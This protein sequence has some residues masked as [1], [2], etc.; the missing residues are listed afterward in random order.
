MQF[1]KKKVFLAV[2]GLF[3]FYLLCRVTPMTIHLPYCHPAWHQLQHVGLL[4]NTACPEGL[5]LLSFH[6]FAISLQFHRPSSEFVKMAVS[7]MSKL[8]YYYS[9]GHFSF[10]IPGFTAFQCFTMRDHMEICFIAATHRM[11][12]LFAFWVKF[13]RKVQTAV[14]WV[15]FSIL[16]M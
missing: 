16:W 13:K 9:L 10:Y 6:Y 8:L 7:F 5:N 4:V 12:M 1:K 2:T 15:F 14:L 3:F 11:E